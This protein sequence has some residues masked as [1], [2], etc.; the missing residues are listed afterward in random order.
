MPNSFVKLVQPHTFRSQN[1]WYEKTMNAQMHPL[2]SYFMHLGNKRIAQRYAY[3]NPEVNQTELLNILNKK[4]KY[5]RWAGA[6][7]MRTTSNNGKQQMIVIETNS[8]PSGQKSFPLL[9]ENNELGGYY[10]LLT[11]SFLPLVKKTRTKGEVAVLFDK[12]EMETSGYAAAIASLLD[13]PIYL[14][15]YDEHDTSSIIE[16]KEGQ[17]YLNVKNQDGLED[18]SVPLKA[19]FRYVTERP[20]NRIPVKTKT[21]IYNPIVACLA[22]G[23]NKLMAA[24]AYNFYNGQLEQYGLQISYPE[25]I[26]DVNRNEVRLWVA[27]FG[28][29]AVV[30]VPYGHAGQGVYIITNEKQLDAFLEIEFEYEQFIVQQLVGHPDWSSVVQDDVFFQVG[31]VPNKR[32]E[33]YVFDVRMMVCNTAQGFKPMVIYSRKTAK[34][35]P[36][37]LNSKDVNDVLIT[38]LSSL[39]PDGTW[40]TDPSRLLLMDNRDFNKL[41]LSL[42]NLIEGYIQTVLATTAIDEMAQNLISTKGNLKRKL[43]RSLNDDGALM[44]EILKQ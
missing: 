32:G 23:R 36:S 28:Y 2:V 5:F 8:C 27:Q 19:V 13:K 16:E 41:G 40:K 37:E 31:T 25:T 1:H 24:K 30:K 3:L 38:N 42:D 21:L 12:N 6:D 9:D 17:L 22:G 29:K 20:W 11:E 18:T 34:P 35:M 44:S 14:V 4:T 39:N 10:R 26:W 7:L 33:S 43:F 15:Y